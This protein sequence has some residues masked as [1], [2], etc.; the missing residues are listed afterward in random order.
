MKH[1]FLHFSFLR[2]T[3]IILLVCVT[4][5]CKNSNG[6]NLHPYGWTP[7]EQYFDTLTIRA[8]KIFNR[9]Q[10]SLA[11]Q[12]A[13]DAL[14]NEAEN[15]PQ[16]PVMQWRSEYWRGRLELRKGNFDDGIALMESALSKVDSTK[17]PYDRD[18]I[19]WNLD[20]DFHS[21]SVDLY[22]H[23][24]DMADKMQ[25]YGDLPLQADYTMQLGSLLNDIGDYNGGLALLDK[26]DYLFT[27]AG[28]E[29]QV[30]NN[31]INRANVYRHQKLPE[32]GDTLLR[33]VL[34]NKSLLNH[35]DALDLVLSNIYELSGDTAVLRRAWLNSILDPRLSESNAIYADY[36]SNEK[37]KLN[38]W[39]SASYYHNIAVR[40][41]DDIGIPISQMEHYRISYLIY[42]HKQQ[43]DSAFY[44]LNKSS[45]LADTIRQD[46]VREEI[47]NINLA[48]EISEKQLNNQLRHR[49]SIIVLLSVIFVI[50]LTG[51]IITW[52]LY[53]RIQRDK[54]NRM[55]DLIEIERTKR[56]NT[57]MRILLQENVS[58]IDSVEANVNALSE[59][60]TLAPSDLSEIRS[61]IKSHNRAENLRQDFLDTFS[62]INPDFVEKM[63]AAHPSLTDSEMRLCIYIALGLDI[64]H[65]ARILG[66]RSESV[67]QARWRLR[68]KL[69]I[70]PDSNLD[71]EI[72]RFLQ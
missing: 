10:D 41:F 33:S 57:A 42:E 69:K 11:S 47:A 66:I 52:I 45:L 15:H 68:N 27:K 54:I 7:T 46:E 32:K 65:I 55:N 9:S 28:M 63:R 43:W 59:K 30:I 2:A 44:Y 6:D 13:V 40:N 48:R 37:I 25:K 31:V 50:I 20:L 22:N 18:R 60:N 49:K 14:R 61:A 71:A 3:V 72:K 53:R 70:T 29:D 38:D 8:E 23:L 62:E 56:K 58:V 17:Y 67:K 34:N 12:R 4:S 64:K 19:L 36:L 24:S 51:G 26:A 16:N 5:G 1:P 21:P 35:P 39:D